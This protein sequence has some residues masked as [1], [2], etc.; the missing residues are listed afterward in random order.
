MLLGGNGITASLEDW[1]ADSDRG[2]AQVQVDMEMM[3]PRQ[4]M[5]SLSATQRSALSYMHDKELFTQEAWSQ[6][7]LQDIDIVFPPGAVP[8][9]QHEQ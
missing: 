5:S 1:L 4:Q 7:Q 2:K 9:P 6:L 3:V 8:P